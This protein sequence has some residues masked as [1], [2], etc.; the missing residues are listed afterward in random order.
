MVRH[1]IGTSLLLAHAIAVF[2][3]GAAFAQTVSNMGM[4]APGS[5][6]PPSTKQVGEMLRN[7]LGSRSAII[8]QVPDLAP[9]V[10]P[11]RTAGPS[12]PSTA[13]TLPDDD[14]SSVIPAPRRV[15]TNPSVAPN[16]VG[17][18]ND[19]S[20]TLTFKLVVGTEATSITMGPRQI[21]TI[22]IDDASAKLTGSIQTGSTP[23]SLDLSRGGI[24]VLR[25]QGD[26]WVLAAL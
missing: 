23:N 13:P 17:F 11:G 4:R 14:P 15:L 22:A 12:S 18:F 9:E 3:A 10:W 19:S 26:H 2:G 5:T 7:G 21:L 6:E 1:K 25:A 20:S 8:M 24:Y 16:H